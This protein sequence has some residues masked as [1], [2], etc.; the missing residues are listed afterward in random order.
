MRYLLETFEEYQDKRSS[1]IW[2]V[3]DSMGLVANEEYEFLFVKLL[4]DYDDFRIPVSKYSIARALY[5][6]TGNRYTYEDENKEM[7]HIVTLTEEIAKARRVIET[8]RKRK[9]TYEEMM[10]LDRVY[11]PPGW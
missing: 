5:L 11:R 2:S 9:R 8:T 3:V 4:D 6:S 10:I 1:I 7:A